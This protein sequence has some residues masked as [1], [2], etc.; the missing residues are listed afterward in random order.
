MFKVKWTEPV[1]KGRRIG[2]GRHP[3]KRKGRPPFQFAC[4]TRNPLKGKH[5]EFPTRQKAAQ[6]IRNHRLDVNKDTVVIV[7]PSGELERFHP[8]MN[9]GHTYLDP[10][11]PCCY[12]GH[13]RD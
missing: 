10:E 8:L 7:H 2:G 6:W 11:A 9:C 3:K 4:H 12:C 13:Y 5:C 1:L